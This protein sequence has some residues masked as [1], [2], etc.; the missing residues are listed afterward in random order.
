MN[1]APRRM[2]IPHPTRPTIM[3]PRPAINIPP[4]QDANSL[5]PEIVFFMTVVAGAASEAIPKVVAL[6]QP[7]QNLEVESIFAPQWVQYDPIS[8]ILYFLTRYY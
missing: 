2:A 8:S 5:F 4:N 1:M 3:C 6:P 7:E